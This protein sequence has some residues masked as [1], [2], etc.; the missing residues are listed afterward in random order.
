MSILVTGAA[1]FIGSNFVHFLINHTTEQVVS[2]DA[3]TYAGH[4]ANLDGLPAD[5][6]TFVH[7]NICDAQA[8]E[9]VLTQ[10]NIQK[11]VHFAAESHV[12]RSIASAAP[13]IQTNVLGTQCLLDAAKQHNIQRFVHVSTDEVY[14]SLSETEP[15]FTEEHPIQ[16]NSPYAASKASSDLL[17]RAYVETHQFPALITRCSNNYGPY[18]FPEKLIPLMIHHAKQGK[19]LPVYGQGLN[20]RDWIHVSDH[21]K[22]IYAVLTKGRDGEVYNIGGES[23]RRNIDIVKTIIQ[24]VGASENLIEY[25]TDRLGHDFR[26]AINISKIK[27]ELDWEPEVSFEQ[28]LADTIAWYNSHD[29]WIEAVVQSI[30]ATDDRA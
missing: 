13:F 25:V 27:Q 9:T 15:A 14:G 18:Q 7:G 23:E 10:H 30:G 22:G 1:G 8:L 16:P 29:D 26:Y 19:P 17:V 11:I 4:K 12:D 21:C 28:G 20:I 6:H 3:L 5:R 2:Y 24:A